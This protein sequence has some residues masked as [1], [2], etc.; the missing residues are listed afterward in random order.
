MYG[1]TKTWPAA[2]ST[3]F[4]QP[5]AASHCR[6]LHGYAL[7]VTLDF[8][9]DH[10]DGNNW[11]VDFGSLASLKARLERDFDHKTVVATSDPELPWFRDGD[12]R[13]VLDLVVL[14]AVG[15][16]A[17]AKH[18]GLL[19]EA[20]LAANI[21]TGLLGRVYLRRATVAEHQG[22]SAYWEPTHAKSL[23]WLP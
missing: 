4:R 23:T 16:E 2:F 6:F 22:N 5:G 17:F 21:P 14:E 11:V 20:W 18:I 15:C 9:A 12:D 19:T 8:T 13:G 7:T 1:S 10:L 3:A